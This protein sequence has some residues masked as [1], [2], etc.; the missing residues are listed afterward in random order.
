MHFC[1]H[2]ITYIYFHFLLGFF[3]DFFALVVLRIISFVRLKFACIKKNAMESQKIHAVTSNKKR[4]KKKKCSSRL[5]EIEL[6]LMVRNIAV[7]NQMQGREKKKRKKL[8]IT[9]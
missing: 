5:R 1:V 7:V 3:F 6:H 2:F 4:S 9:A 8:T